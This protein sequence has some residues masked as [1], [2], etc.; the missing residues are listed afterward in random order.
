MA[1]IVKSEI[2]VGLGGPLAI[3][4]DR[5]L[6]KAIAGDTIVTLEDGSRHVVPKELMTALPGEL[7]GGITRAFSS[8][9]APV[10]THEDGTP[11]TQDELRVLAERDR[12][13]IENAKQDQLRDGAPAPF[14]MPDQTDP[15]APRVF[16]RDPV[17][18]EQVERPGL[19]VDSGSYGYGAQG[20]GRTGDD[21]NPEVRDA[22]TG[23]LLG[24]EHHPVGTL[25]P[26]VADIRHGGQGNIAR[27]G[28][29]AAREGEVAKTEGLRDPLTGDLLR[30]EAYPVGTLPVGAAAEINRGVSPGAV[31][32]GTAPGVPDSYVVQDGPSPSA[33]AERLSKT[34]ATG[35]NYPQAPGRTVPGN[36]DI[37]DL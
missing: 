27:F 29:L 3:Q 19:L 7:V 37:N 18:G 36:D 14:A 4:S 23:E 25:R 21:P 6:I 22:L 5:G 34:R 9:P 28:D 15:N 1:R 11:L 26:G 13:V 35:S 31:H 16:Q 10:P 33:T 20:P 12:L 32:P 24:P 8:D 2:F 30:P 17:T